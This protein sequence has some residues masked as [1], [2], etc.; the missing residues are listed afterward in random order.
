MSTDPTCKSC[1]ADHP[2]DQPCNLYFHGGTNRLVPG[3]LVLPP[4]RTWAKRSDQFGALVLK[5]AVQKVYRAD[6]V[7]VIDD[8]RGACIFAACFPC[9]RGR[10]GK[11]Y[12]VSPIGDLEEDKDFDGTGSWA[13]PMARVLQVV[14]V[15]P[16]FLRYTRELMLLDELPG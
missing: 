13:V 3:D 12:V 9:P 4:V 16:S 15:S 14:P 6:R 8:V 10:L 2:V 5:R 11:V 7:Y 1:Y